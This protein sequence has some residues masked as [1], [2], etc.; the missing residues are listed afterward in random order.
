MVVKERVVS[1][2]R[3]KRKGKKYVAVVARPGRRTRRVHFGATGYE[4]FRDA[5][6]CGAYS[7]GDHGD[8]KRRKNYFSRHSGVPTKREALRREWRRSRGSLTPKL[9]SHLYLW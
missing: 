4:Q 7:R 1:I 6:G 8:S 5:T 2:A 3:S 9:L